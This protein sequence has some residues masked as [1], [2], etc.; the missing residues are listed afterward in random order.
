[1]WGNVLKIPV[2]IDGYDKYSDT[3]TNDTFYI[4]SVRKECRNVKVSRRSA[5]RYARLIYLKKQNKK[6]SCTKSL[7]ISI[8]SSYRSAKSLQRLCVYVFCE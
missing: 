7:N 3:F 2:N 4:S 8:V 6:T 1:M 5:T